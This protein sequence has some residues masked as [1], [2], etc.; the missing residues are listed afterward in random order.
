[1]KNQDILVSVIITC[2]NKE[3]YIEKAI[4]SVLDQKTTFKFEIIIVDDC[5]T[6]ES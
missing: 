6:D 3:K 5:S 1:M 4:K 2:Y